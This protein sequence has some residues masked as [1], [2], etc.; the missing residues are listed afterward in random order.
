M[1]K[2]PKCKTKNNIPQQY[3]KVTKKESLEKNSSNNGSLS[4]KNMMLN[5]AN[6]ISQKKLKFN[7][8]S[9]R[10]FG[11]DISSKIK[12]AI[13]PNIE[14]NH[15]VRKSLSNISNI[16]GDKVKIYI[17]YIIYFFQ[18]YRFLLV[19]KI[20][21]LVLKLQ[22]IKQKK[23]WELIKLIHYQTKQIIN[24]M[25]QNLDRQF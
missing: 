2:I 11:D 12:N 13:S 25:L 7:N 9:S 5:K 20:I 1:Y 22:K 23:F 15:N 6:K 21:L 16:A 24:Y 14:H 4:N 17:F 19:L 10:H 3:I 18:I 8:D